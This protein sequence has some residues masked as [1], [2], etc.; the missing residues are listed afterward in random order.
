[1]WFIEDQNMYR[2]QEDAAQLFDFY[3]KANK[4]FEHRTKKL[5]KPGLKFLIKHFKMIDKR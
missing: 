3:P 2:I 5:H 1:M 4:V